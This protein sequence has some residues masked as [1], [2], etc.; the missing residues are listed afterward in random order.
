MELGMSTSFY[1]FA[2]TKREVEN[3]KDLLM[4]FQNHYILFTR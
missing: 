1:I 2:L 3:E 4:A